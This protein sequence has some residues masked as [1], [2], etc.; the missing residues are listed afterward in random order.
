MKTWHYYYYYFS[1]Y[2]SVGSDSCLRRDA[3]TDN[4]LVRLFMK[5]L[6]NSFRR[7]AVVSLAS[8]PFVVF[9]EVTKKKIITVTWRSSSISSL[10]VDYGCVLAVFLRYGRIFS[11][12]ENVTLW[13]ETFNL[14]WITVLPSY[15]WCL[16]MAAWTGWCSPASDSSKRGRNGR[17]VG[18]QVR[19]PHRLVCDMNHTESYT[20]NL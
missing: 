14:P 19:G 9:S 1:L 18:G 17:N 3:D 12:G 8:A 5:K 7:T 10:A 16:C 15:F 20:D 11:A 13:H 6:P 2:N 4:N